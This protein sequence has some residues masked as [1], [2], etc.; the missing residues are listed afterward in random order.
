MEEVFHSFFATIPGDWFRKNNIAE[1]EG[2][3]AS[4]FYAYFA[5]LGLDIKVEDPTNHGRMDMTLFF[6]GRCYIFE[7]KVV[8]YAD[9]DGSALEQIKAKKYAEKYASDY[10][11]IHLIGV[12]FRKEDRNIVRFEVEQA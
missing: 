10:N 5:S 7:F 6:E 1:Y 12:E 11:E 2:F 9:G 8:E 4:V 3:Y